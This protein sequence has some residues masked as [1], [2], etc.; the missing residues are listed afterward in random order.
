[1]DERYFGDPCEEK[2]HC[3]LDGV[4]ARGGIPS[5]G[6]GGYD[7]GVVNVLRHAR[8]CF[9]L[10]PLY[11]IIG[12]FH[13]AGGNEKIITQSVRDTAEFSRCARTRRILNSELFPPNFTLKKWPRKPSQR[14]FSA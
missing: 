7:D 5:I 12:G 1:M 14:S 11:G 13:L 2:R 4:L 6:S 9:P 3:C 10:V 8:T